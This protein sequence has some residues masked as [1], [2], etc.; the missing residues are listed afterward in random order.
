MAGITAFLNSNLLAGFTAFLS[1]NLWLDSPSFLC[2]IVAVFRNNYVVISSIFIIISFY[3][4]CQYIFYIFLISIATP[5][6]NALYTFI[7]IFLIQ[8]SYYQYHQTYNYYYKSY[9]YHIKYSLFYSTSYLINK[10]C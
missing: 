2:Y 6:I 1:S 8:C 10:C 9:I 4:L 3:S 5:T 7:F